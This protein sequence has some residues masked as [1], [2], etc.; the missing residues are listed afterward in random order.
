MLTD[1]G[2]AVLDRRAVVEDLLGGRVDGGTV[3]L[4]G[5]AIDVGRAPEL[6]D[7]LAWMVS[8]AVALRDGRRELGTTTVGRHAAL[9]RSGGYAS[10]VLG[11]LPDRDVLSEVEDQLFRFER[12]IDASPELTEALIS[13]VLPAEVRAGVVDELLARRALEPTRRLAGYLTRIGRPRDF[14]EL[15][16]ALVARVGLEADRRVAV[17]RAVVPL[18]TEEES[19]LA[20]ALSRVVGQQIEVRVTVDPSVLGGFVATIGDTMVDASVR[21]RLDSL[22]ERLTLPAATTT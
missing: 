7:D 12:A 10:A 16:Q 11:N 22:R 20:A 3:R 14:V 19:R 2:V 4:L 15:L 21:H 17:V 9:E 5:Q 13:P 18:T 6:P 1:P 8:R